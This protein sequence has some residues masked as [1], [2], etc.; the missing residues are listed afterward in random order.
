MWSSGWRT[1]SSRGPGGGGGGQPAVEGDGG[2]LEEE[3]DSPTLDIG[4]FKRLKCNIAARS[5][6]AAITDEEWAGARI[7][8]RLHPGGRANRRGLDLGWK[9]DTTALEGRR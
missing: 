5:T 1:R 8:V 4:D 6:F 9:Q 2:A 7:G 3:L